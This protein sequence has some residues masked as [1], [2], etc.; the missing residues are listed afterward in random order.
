MQKSLRDKFQIRKSDFV[1]F[2]TSHSGIKKE[3][4]LEQ[5]SKTTKY[6]GEAES[7]EILN[8][9]GFQYPSRAR[10]LSFLMCKGGV[11]KTTSCFFVAQRL[12]AYGAR[13]LIIDADPQGNLS[14]AFD[15]GRYNFDIDE[16]TP[17]L[18]DLLSK[19][20]TFEEAVVAISPH[21]HLIPSTPINATLEAKIR[22]LYKNPSVA[23]RKLIE[24]VLN[25]YDF[26]LV[27]CAPALNLTNTAIVAASHLVVLPVTP[28]R[29]SQMGLQQTLVEISQ[30]EEDFQLRVDKR[31]VFT[32]F[33]AREKSSAE[34]LAKISE[35]RK[36]QMFSTYI[37][38]ATDVK[39][40]ITGNEDLFSLNHSNAKQDYD[41][42][43]RELLTFPFFK[44]A[45]SL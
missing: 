35:E 30:I 6:L 15:L 37:R 45:I 19:T 13:V 16:E 22:D 29:F 44:S 31:I 34:Y 36:R 24:P 5:L 25:R 12:A 38:T 2:V 41:S 11:G 4:A 3:R 42:L 23:L 9:A 39:N 10:V 18:V 7:R 32:R 40:V 17:V 27:D 8:L 28:D 20:C 33:D 1:D 43:T 21:L 14:A 26:I